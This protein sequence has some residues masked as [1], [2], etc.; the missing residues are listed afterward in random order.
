MENV[1][2]AEIAML[3][4]KAKELRKML[5]TMIYQAQS[6]HPGGV[7]ILCRYYYYIIFLCNEL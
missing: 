1:K 3:K 2:K 5:L 6:G 7:F 4:A